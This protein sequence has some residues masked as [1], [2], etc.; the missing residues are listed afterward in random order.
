MILPRQK[1]LSFFEDRAP[2]TWERVVPPICLSTVLLLYLK[3]GLGYSSVV[4]HVLR[5]MDHTWILGH[6]AGP[7]EFCG[8][9][10]QC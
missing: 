4:E 10:T 1:A 8:N 3:L 2:G 7:L 9:D 6:T 5:H